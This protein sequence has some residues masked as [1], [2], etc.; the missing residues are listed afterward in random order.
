VKDGFEF[1]RSLAHKLLILTRNCSAKT[2]TN[3]R[4]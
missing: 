1:F 2:D 3:S 4:Y